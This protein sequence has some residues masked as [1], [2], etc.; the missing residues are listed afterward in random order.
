MKNVFKKSSSSFRLNENFTNTELD[1]YLKYHFQLGN[2]NNIFWVQ[3]KEGYVYALKE[4]LVTRV[5]FYVLGSILMKYEF[6]PRIFRV[7]IKMLR[8]LKSL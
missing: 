6:A 8:E 2:Q 7:A 3:W 5:S 1:S 4:Y